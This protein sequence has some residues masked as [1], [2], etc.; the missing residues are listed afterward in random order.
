M[1]V[2]T[3]SSD[4]HVVAFVFKFSKAFTCFLPW[5]SIIFICF[6]KAFPKGEQVNFAC[7][8]ICCWLDGNISSPV[9]YSC[10]WILSDD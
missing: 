6:S 3:S 2:L 8:I 1:G 10:F 7:S 5:S 9:R 4:L